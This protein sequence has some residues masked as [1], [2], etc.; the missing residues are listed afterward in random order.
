MVVVAE[1][2]EVT[3][4]VSEGCLLEGYEGEMWEMREEHSAGGW[5]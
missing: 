3:K 2:M 4:R 1:Q 5:R